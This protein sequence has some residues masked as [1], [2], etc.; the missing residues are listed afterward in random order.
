MKKLFITIWHFLSGIC[1]KLKNLIT[2][3]KSRWSPLVDIPD[4]VRG[5]IGAYFIYD[6]RKSVIDAGFVSRLHELGISVV[7]LNTNRK[8][9]PL[10]YDEWYA[11]FETFRFTGIRLM[12]YCYEAVSLS[13]KWTDEQIKAV[14]SHPSFYG[15]IAEDEVSYSSY[16]GSWIKRFHAQKF[17]DGSRKWPK[18]AI[19]YF[20][21]ISTLP[22]KHIGENYE[23][24]LNRW[25]DAIDIA[26]ADMYPIIASAKD[27]ADTEGD[28]TPVYPK[29]TNPEKWFDY[30]SHHL[31]FTKEHPELVHRLYMHACKHVVLDADK[32]PYIS[33]P[34]P[35][36]KTLSIQAYA[37]LM[38]GSEGLM[39]FLGNDSNN[40]I[41]G[42]FDSA[43]KEDF[44]PN[45][46]TYNKL[47]NLFGCRKF[48]NF[49]RLIGNSAIWSL[50]AFPDF[51]VATLV[52]GGYVY[53]A[54]LNFSLSETVSHS[55]TD[56]N[57][58]AGLQVLDLQNGLVRTVEKGETF[59]IE[60]GDIFV[61]RIIEVSED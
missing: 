26:H 3:K 41:S 53:H 20:P 12:L 40:G 44:T 7:Y 18:L 47:K 37:N 4:T 32:K 43:F 14:N 34:K 21:K 45:A 6:K 9:A 27:N 19:C 50:A 8:E 46:D 17:S 33:Y 57:Y 25:S 36:D 52:G 22:A 58:V 31:L 56:I 11:I 2:G 15:W 59:T 61:T 10:S 1:S 60:A 48:Q 38:A 49:R 35:T 16:E 30:L 51:Y 42:F 55:Y 39:L 24:Y 29:A 23:D 5:E 13:P 54:Y 28:G